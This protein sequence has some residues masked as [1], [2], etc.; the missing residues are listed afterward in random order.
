MGRYNGCCGVFLTGFVRRD[1][2]KLLNTV[3]LRWLEH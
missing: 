1:V 3:E 2:C